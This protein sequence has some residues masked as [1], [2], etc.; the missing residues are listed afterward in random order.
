MSYLNTS[1]APLAQKGAAHIPR[2]G[3][4]G[5]TNLE[6]PLT[7]RQKVEITLQSL[8]HPEVFATGDCAALEGVE[9]PKSGVYAVRHGAILYRNLA[10]AVGG[11]A[12]VPYRFEPRALALISCGDRYAIASRGRWSA[13]GRWVWLWKD[14]VDRRWVASLRL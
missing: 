5:G 14:W 1:R 2:G 4:L 10:A 9:E 12:L 13:A 8:S 3:W 6:A 7:R 11:H